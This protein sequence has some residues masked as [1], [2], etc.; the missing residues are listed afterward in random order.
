MTNKI[1]FKINEF[2]NLNKYPKDLFYRGNLDLLKKQKVSIVG[3]RKPISYTKNLTYTISSLLSTR[4]ICIVSGGAMGVDAI[5]HQG[6]KSNNTICILANGLNIKYPKVNKN[7]LTSIENKGLLLSTYKDDTLATKYSFVLRNELV[8]ALSDILIIMQ[9]DQNS[10][11]IR[12]LEYALKMNKKVYTIAHRIEDNKGLIPYIKKGLVE[13][14][15]DINEFINSI[16]TNKN[17]NDDDE[18]LNY[19]KTN[20]SYEEAIF[21]YQDKIFEYELNCIFKVENGI[22]KVIY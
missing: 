12:S 15:Y 14:I 3:T 20:P 5:A 21:K 17:E 1:E 18:I 11:S 16:K 7:L 19:L 4:D 2:K 10:G 22:C 8:V 6:A 13:V 9:A